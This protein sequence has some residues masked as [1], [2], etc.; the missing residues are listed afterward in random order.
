MEPQ[1]SH[2]RN[3]RDQ[4][5]PVR[6]V[7]HQTDRWTHESACGRYRIE[8]FIPGDH[9]AIFDANPPTARYRILKLTPNW[10]GEISGSET[11]IETC[12]GIC[13]DNARL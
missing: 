13:E 9:E 10:W 1:T 2:E 12:K 8:G 3:G 4:Q 6:L 11:D 7:W 5:E